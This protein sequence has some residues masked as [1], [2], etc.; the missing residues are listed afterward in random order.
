MVNLGSDEFTVQDPAQLTLELAAR[1]VAQSPA[2]QIIDIRTRAQRFEG[3]GFIPAS[4]WIPEEE[5]LADPTVLE[6]VCSV[7]VCESGRRSY[8]LVRRLYAQG[9]EVAELE[10]GMLGWSIARLPV[11][12][13]GP[14]EVRELMPDELAELIRGR[15]AALVPAVVLDALLLAWSPTEAC[16]RLDKLA[17]H[18]R[19]SG[20]SLERLSRAFGVLYAQI[21][22]V[23]PSLRLDEVSWDQELSELRGL[24]D[25]P[26]MVDQLIDALEPVDNAEALAS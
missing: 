22:H 6:G 23:V 24:L 13:V 25:D 26:C 19:S 2:L 17:A 21:P 18:A 12:G 20:V 14:A 10:G 5:L 3:L 15:C 16:R 9:Y 11:C 1:D 8:G 7:L 4:L